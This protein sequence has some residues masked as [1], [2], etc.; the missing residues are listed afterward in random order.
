[1][2]KKT[3]EFVHLHNHSEYSLLDGAARLTDDKGKPSEFIQ[4]MAK[5]G[6][7]AL[8]LTDHG[9]LFGAVE[10]YK[11][12]K[13]VGIQPIIGMEAYVAPGSR[14]DKDQRLGEAAYHMTILAHSVEGYQN[15][16]KLSS[17][18][19]LEGFHYKPRID[20][21][22]LGKHAKGLTAFSGWFTLAQRKTQKN[23]IENWKEVVIVDKEIANGS[24]VINP[25]LHIKM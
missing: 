14:F 6:Y 25:A 12:C 10:F 11:V 23:S 22:I 4:T 3:A 24:K 16:L 18:A 8:A 9:N 1:M 2:T 20:K 21:E 5:M 19:Y 13:D 7:P 15:L 17:A